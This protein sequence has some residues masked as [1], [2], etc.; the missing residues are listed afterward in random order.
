MGQMAQNQENFFAETKG[1]EAAQ[2]LV[3][4][5]HIRHH[6]TG[7]DTHQACSGAASFLTNTE[8]QSSFNQKGLCYL[9]TKYSLTSGA[10]HYKKKGITDFLDMQLFVLAVAP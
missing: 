8:Q 10:C 2:S 6:Q 4:E 7:W 3:V 1:H 9:K 5:G